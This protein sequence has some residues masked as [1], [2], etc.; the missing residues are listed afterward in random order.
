MPYYLDLSDEFDGR[1]IY[2]FVC[3]KQRPDYHL[4]PHVILFESPDRPG[5]EHGFR[6]EDTKISVSDRTLDNIV[7]HLFNNKFAHISAE[8]I[9][10]AYPIYFEARI[11]KL[12]DTPNIS[13]IPRFKSANRL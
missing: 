12:N 9:Y 4:E 10:Q 3:N 8:N 7:T 13:R 2:G 11:F 1:P 5:T 6:V